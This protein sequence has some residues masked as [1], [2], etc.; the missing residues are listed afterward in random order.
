MCDIVQV[1]KIIKQGNWAWWLNFRV[2]CGGKGTQFGN[3]SS[4]SEVTGKKRTI[5]VPMVHN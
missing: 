2:L 4:Q 5:L 3:A 1:S